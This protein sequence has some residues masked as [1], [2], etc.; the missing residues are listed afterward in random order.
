MSIPAYLWLYD[1]N[2]VLIKGG[3]EI[4]NRGGAI[5][6]QSFIHSLYHNY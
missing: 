1:K 5:E 4:L 3:S 6:V 2:G